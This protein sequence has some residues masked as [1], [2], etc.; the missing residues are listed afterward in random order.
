MLSYLIG[1]RDTG[2][3]HS[4]PA[5]FAALSPHTVL[6]CSQ[7]R[8][9]RSRSAAHDRSAMCHHTPARPLR[10]PPVRVAVARHQLLAAA[11]RCQGD[12]ERGQLLAEPHLVERDIGRAPEL[13]VVVDVAR[14]VALMCACHV[15]NTVLHSRAVPVSRHRSPRVPRSARTRCRSRAGSR[16]HAL[17]RAQCT[18]RGPC[19]RPGTRLRAD[20]SSRTDLAGRSICAAVSAKD[21]AAIRA[22]DRGL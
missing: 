22:Y 9:S 19:T 17:S 6:L 5:L 16:S 21:G 18:A 3:C 14:L 4:R 10:V 1:A 2:T 15:L 20:L 13:L 11:D 8:L 12:D 7:P